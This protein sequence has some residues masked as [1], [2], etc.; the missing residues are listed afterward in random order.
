[1]LLTLLS[2]LVLMSAIL[3]I[4]AE[5]SGTRRSV[6]VFKPLT[7]ALII[8]I[9][10]QGKSGASSFYRY[11]IVAGLLCSL[12]G[13]VC[14][15]L[16]RDRFLEGLVCFLV[17]HVFYIGAFTLDGGLSLFVWAGVPLLVYGGLMLRGLWP[18]LGRL[19]GPVSVYVGLILLMAWQALNRCLGAGPEGSGMAA[20]GA[21]LFVASDSLLA[22]RRFAGGFRAAQAWVLGTYFVAQWLIALSA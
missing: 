6:Y 15:M 21:L 3:T 20:A 7:V 19:R 10:L 4:R 12:A 5:H 17:A 13:D 18:R 11:M 8:L 14:L 22:R 2:M 1:M 16:P 9:A